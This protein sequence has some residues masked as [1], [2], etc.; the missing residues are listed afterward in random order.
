MGRTVGNI[1]ALTLNFI[2]LAVCSYGL[3]DSFFS[4]RVL[5][6]QLFEAGQWQFW[7]NWSLTVTIAVLALG[8]VAHA[9]KSQYLFRLKNNI[10][11]IGLAMETVV[12]IVYWPLRLF[13]LALLIKDD[14]P[15]MELPIST[16]LSVHLM[17]VVG[18]IVDYLAFMPNWTF[19]RSSAFGVCCIITTSYWFWL[20]YIIDLEKG[21]GFPYEFLNHPSA[22]FR[23]TIFALVGLIGLSSAF[24]WPKV[25]AWVAGKEKEK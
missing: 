3:Y 21:A 23:L 11:P 8:V 7:T 12:T 25:H 18:L 9:T 15:K 4:E 14:A 17:P 24:L 16:D 10:H 6:P 1:Y 13:F 5:P 19:K 20:H 2:S 22:Y